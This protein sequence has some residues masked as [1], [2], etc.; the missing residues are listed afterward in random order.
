MKRFLYTALLCVMALYAVAQQDSIKPLCPVFTAVEFE[1]GGVR[2]IDTYLSP[3][4]YKGWDI[5]LDVELMKAMKLDN[6]SWV[7]QQRL[8][9]NYGQTRLSISGAGLT[10][11]GGLDYSFA[12]MRRSNTP[13]DG[14]QLYYGGDVS[15]RAQGLYNYH[16]GNN[17]TSVKADISLGLTGMVVYNFSLGKLPLT[18]RYQMNLPLVG[19]FAQP[20]YAESYYEVWLGNYRDFLHCG[21]WANRFDMGN[22]I[23]IDMHMGSW[24]LR[25]GYHNRIDTTYEN[26]NR[27]Q[28]VMH[29]FVIGFAG[30]LAGVD[31][32]HNNRPVIRALYNISQ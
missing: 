1:A 14:L 20:Q 27:Y 13:I 23:T 17:P 10:R 15:L 32:K 21:T 26:N 2:L 12:M 30:D 5:A 16:G 9:L 4:S 28:L 8:G 25:V 6:Y 11:E 19:V 18:A 24:A 31:Y 7:W 3:W 29:N 22:R